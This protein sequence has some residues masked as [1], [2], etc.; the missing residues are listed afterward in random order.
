[1]SSSTSRSDLALSAACFASHSFICASI[2]LCCSSQYLSSMMTQLLVLS[3]NIA[4]PC[5]L[6]VANHDG[7]AV[8]ISVRVKFHQSEAVHP[9]GRAIA[10]V[11]RIELPQDWRDPSHPF[12][13]LRNRTDACV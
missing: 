9:S 12:L 2:F 13:G 1:M 8:K 4:S 7:I 5:K 11:F 6:A 3:I 10:N